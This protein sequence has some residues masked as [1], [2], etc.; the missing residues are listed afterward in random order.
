M[1]YDYTSFLYLLY[2]I[3]DFVLS[4]LTALGCVLEVFQYRIIKVPWHQGAWVKIPALPGTSCITLPYLFR[5]HFLNL[6]ICKVNAPMIVVTDHRIECI[7]TYI[8]IRIVPG[9]H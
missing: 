4:A 1:P 5:L 9:T 8:A 7:N 3:T 6:F 2:C